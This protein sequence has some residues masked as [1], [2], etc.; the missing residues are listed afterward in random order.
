MVLES[1]RDT[2]FTPFEPN[3]PNGV[4]GNHGYHP[5]KGPQPVMLMVGPDFKKGLQLSRR[6][7]LD[8]AATICRIFGWDLPD[9]DGTV[10]EEVLN[11]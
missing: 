1:F 2:I 7:T 11:V 9:M 10:I 8:M 4:R 6:S 5:D 3:N